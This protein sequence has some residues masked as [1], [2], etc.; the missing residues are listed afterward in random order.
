VRFVLY[1]MTL[2]FVI[3]AFATL[4]SGET[5]QTVAGFLISALMI[6]WSKTVWDRRRTKVAAAKAKAQLDP[7]DADPQDSSSENLETELNPAGSSSSLKSELDAAR[8]E[9]EKLKLE[10]VKAK[11]EISSELAEAKK[12]LSEQRNGARA[13]EEISSKLLAEIGKRAD[14][15]S[16]VAK[17]VRS[18]LET[19]PKP[20]IV[21]EGISGEQAILDA[22]SESAPEEKAVDQ[23]V[24][25][26]AFTL[27]V[28]NSSHEDAN[29]ESEQARN[30]PARNAWRDSQGNALHVGAKVHFLANSRGQSVSIPGTLLGEREG[31]ARIEVGSG[32]LLPR[33]DYSIP[34][35]VV[36]LSS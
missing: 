20:D 34:W 10:V 25:S 15:V 23:E 27:E 33:N 6:W 14:K 1:A 16:E 36:T 2:M 7:K 13:A 28:S 29:S 30:E 3:Q 5:S 32:A 9:L 12:I 19:P 18:R 21:D 22:S 26:P 24:P 4:F 17:E 11:N 35:A 31:Q 8:S